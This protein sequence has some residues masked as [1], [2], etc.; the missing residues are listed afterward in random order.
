MNIHDRV[1]SRFPLFVA[2]G[3]V[4]IAIQACHGVPNPKANKCRWTEELSQPE[5]RECCDKYNMACRD[6][7]VRNIVSPAEVDVPVKV[8]T[9]T[10]SPSKGRGMGESCT[11]PGVGR[12]CRRPL[13]CRDGIC[14]K[15]KGG[16]P[17][18]RKE[19]ST[20]SLKDHGIQ[21]SGL[22]VALGQR[23]PISEVLKGNVAVL[24]PVRQK[25]RKTVDSVDGNS[26]DVQE[27]VQKTAAEQ[28]VIL[29]ETSSDLGKEANDTCPDSLVVAAGCGEKMTKVLVK[30]PIDTAKVEVDQNEKPVDNSEETEDEQ[31]SDAVAKVVE[32]VTGKPID[33]DTLKDLDSAVTRAMDRYEDKALSEGALE[34]DVEDI[35][36][37]ASSSVK[38][39]LP[40]TEAIPESGFGDKLKSLNPDDRYRMMG[41]KVILTVIKRLRDDVSPSLLEKVASI[42][43]NSS[44]RCRGTDADDSKCATGRWIRENWFSTASSTEPGSQDTKKRSG[45]AKVDS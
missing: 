31:I 27:V 34:V 21:L 30:D 29:S 32:K 23:V 35:L 43:I 14:R 45:T 40:D 44:T 15:K 8:A 12:P 9:G 2:C 37:G 18:V 10:L 7:K 4:A 3:L 5:I 20:E 42:L 26:V 17:S 22:S 25:L 13:E 36:S 16:K 19:K 38:M 33:S 41:N 39:T 1:C 6:L 24:P 11:G 28:K